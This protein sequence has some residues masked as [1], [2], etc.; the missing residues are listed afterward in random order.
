MTTKK[1]YK[2]ALKIVNSYELENNEHDIRLCKIGSKIRYN[3]DSNKTWEKGAI[4]TIENIVDHQNNQIRPKYHIRTE[5]GMSWEA[6][7]HT[8]KFTVVKI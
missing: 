4:Y 5:K 2:E 1:E 3:L 6:Y 8:K 7:P